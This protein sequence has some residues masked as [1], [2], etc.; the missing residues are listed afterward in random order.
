MQKPIPLRPETGRLDL[1][2]P[3]AAFATMRA[4]IAQPMDGTSR[5]PVAVARQIY[6]DNRGI[7]SFLAKAD[8]TIGTTSGWGSPMAHAGVAAFLASMA[9]LSAAAALISAGL[10]VP[11]AQHGLLTVPGRDGAPASGAGVAEGAP[12]PVI[13][14]PLTSAVLT[15]KKAGFIVTI[16]RELAKSEAAPSVFR[17]LLA[18][19]AA[20]TLD[21][22]YFSTADAT[23]AAPAGLLF[24]A[25]S[26]FSGDI[27]TAMGEMAAAVA[28]AGSGQVIFITAPAIA[29]AM[30]IRAP[31]IRATVWPSSAVPAGRLIAADP[32]SIVHGFSS[33]PEIDSADAVLLHMEDTTPLEIVSGSG[34]T[35]ADPVRSLWQTAAVAT[36]LSLP[37]AF[38]TRR[39]GAVVFADN[40]QW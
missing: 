5:D 9:P 2:L 4:F 6:G 8:Q 1:D 14:A 38:A 18:E 23:D 24:G 21:G 17:T 32:K 28:D 40:L 34:P 3:R 33:E 11:I 36:R 37:I 39:T 35:T 7:M 25:S 19:N 22:L 15:P 27:V 16:S 31:D 20:A 13:A 29:A 10:T 12:I 26:G 30:P